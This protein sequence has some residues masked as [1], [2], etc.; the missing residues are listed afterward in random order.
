M[1]CY[2]CGAEIKIEGIITRTDE[3]PHCASDVHCCFNCS[4]Y[5]SAAHNKCRE[6]QSEWVADREKG[7]FCDYF[8]ANTLMPGGKAGPLKSNETREAFENLFKK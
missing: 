5:D 2:H 6:P 3:C 4:N 1:V 7:N 8:I